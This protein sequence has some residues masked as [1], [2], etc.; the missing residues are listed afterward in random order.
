[1]KFS[2]RP[3]S[4]LR[5]AFSLARVDIAANA[6][7]PKAQFVMVLFRLAHWARVGGGVKV[8]LSAPLVVIYRILVEGIMGIELRP[9]TEV[10][11]GLRLYHGVGLV[12]NDRA[13][14]GSNVTLRH[15]VTI[16]SAIDDGPC[17]IIEDNVDI[18][19]GAIIIGGIRI[20][21]ASRI[22]AGAVVVQDMPAGAVARGLAATIYPRREPIGYEGKL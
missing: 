4:T 17:P 11:A 18:G 7:D 9:R 2:E 13:V 5:D 1:M 19:A 8:R 20:G 16:G 3:S 12:V 14:I 22:G 10:G 21:G 15:S 6:G